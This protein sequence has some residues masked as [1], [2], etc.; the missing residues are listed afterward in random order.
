[1]H[2]VSYL[3]FV[4]VWWDNCAPKFLVGFYVLCSSHRGSHFA[5][6]SFVPH[7][8]FSIFSVSVAFRLLFHDQFSSGFIIRRSFP[9]FLSI[10]VLFLII[11]LHRYSSSTPHT[12]SS[13]FVIFTRRHLH[14][15]L[16]RVVTEVPLLSN[17][18]SW[19]IRQKQTL[20]NGIILSQIK[21][22]NYLPYSMT[23]SDKMDKMS[24]AMTGKDF[25]S[26]RT[27]AQKIGFN[28]RP[29]F[30]STIQLKAPGTQPL[31]KDE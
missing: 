12:P 9:P 6:V 14:P 24:I 11:L 25:L 18:P 10:L 20:F 22:L 8:A 3:R 2:T 21:P 19:V 23:Q 15:S 31:T 26:K 17:Q 16:A 29:D 4:R 5:W 13:S 28:V 7:D 30:C 1:M 27:L